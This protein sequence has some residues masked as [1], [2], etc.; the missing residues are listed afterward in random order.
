MQ[1]EERHYQEI[2]EI[3]ITLTTEKN[4]TN[5]L[6]LI[7]NKSM[8]ITHCDGGTLYLYEDDFLHFNMMRTTSLNIYK[9]GSRE[10][11]DL[12]PVPLREENVCAYA[13][14][15][16]AVVNIDDVYHSD[17]FD[18]SGPKNYDPIIQYHT[19]SMLVIPL[20][21]HENELIGVIQLINALDSNG[22]IIPFD[23]FYERIVLSL[24]SQAGVAVSNMRFIHDIKELLNSFVTAMGTAVD[25]RTPYNGSHT[26]NVTRYVREFTAYLHEMHLKNL[27]PEPFDENRIEQLT[28]AAA[29]HDIGKLIIPLSVMDK[30]TRLG[31]E[32]LS[33][34]RNRFEL[35]Q[36]WLEIDY[37][38]G[39][40][41]KHQYQQEIKYLLDSLTMIEKVN[42]MGYLADNL[43]SDLLLLKD[44]RYQREDGTTFAY[45]TEKESQSLLIKRGTLT[46]MERHI[47][48]NHVVMTTNIL[49]NIKFNK[50][51]A[52]VP[53]WAG[54]HHEYL[55]GSGYPL[56][57]T[58]GDLPLDIRILTL[59]DI[60][61][62]LTASDRPYKKALPK[63]KALQILT[64][65]AEKETKLDAQ[66][67]KL[68]CCYVEKRSN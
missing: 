5:L 37:L 30:E 4:Y 3:G 51:Y 6:E 56:H 62:A 7:L 59:T 28:M 46:Q 58:A 35:F 8:E 42:V 18:F 60:Y 33:D 53:R 14:L 24:A 64:E 34:I 65:M 31:K 29:L 16:R 47:M 44:K 45:L 49:E 38:K 32:R 68:F 43:E 66:L 67:V 22:T 9:G 41:E 10:P 50:N 39:K 20:M 63:E 15:H 23:A 1:L 19:Q 54:A 52:N 61:D 57:L 27:F 40:I 48:E 11:I 12:P 25:A 55:D 13:A 26:R 21:N 2:L 36:A 17:R